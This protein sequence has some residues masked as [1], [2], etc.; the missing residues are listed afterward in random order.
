M[1]S[2]CDVVDDS[3]A[4]RCMLDSMQQ[5]PGAVISAASWAASRC[6]RLQGL[7]ATHGGEACLKLLVAMPIYPSAAVVL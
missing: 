3:A 5:Q 4:W 7:Q 2:C 6:Q 1:S